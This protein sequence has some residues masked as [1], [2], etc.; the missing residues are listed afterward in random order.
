M[1]TY[2]EVAGEGIEFAWG[3]S[4]LFY[5]QQPLIMKRSKN[6]FHFLVDRALSEE[7]LS[8]QQM[9]AF[10]RHARQYMLAY[11]AISKQ[12]SEAERQ[13][14]QTDYVE[15]ESETTMS[16]SLMEKCVRL[17]KKRRSHRSAADFDSAFISGVLNKMS[18]SVTETD[19]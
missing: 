1:V 11:H 19:V 8:T 18:K 15:V 7:V 4:K 17:F 13:L 12:K 5:H 3:I 16:H 2:P 9:R 14:Q 10:S 6:L